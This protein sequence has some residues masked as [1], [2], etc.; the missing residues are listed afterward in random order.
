VHAG[1]AATRLVATAH[2]TIK[3]IIPQSLYLSV[4]SDGRGGAGAQTVSVMSNGHY[5]ALTATLLRPTNEV[6]SNV[7][8]SAAA[9]KI[10]AQD[11]ACRAGDVQVTGGGNGRVICTASS[12]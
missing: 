10:I 4:G 8:L 11:A 7:I 2:V 5:A 3:I 9:R 12:P 1:A 6:H